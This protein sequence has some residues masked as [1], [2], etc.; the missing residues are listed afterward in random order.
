[1][2]DFYILIIIFMRDLI[3]ANHKVTQPDLMQ[4]FIILVH[5]E[6]QFFPNQRAEVPH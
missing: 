3:F 6:G 1:M 4:V 2:G 5:A